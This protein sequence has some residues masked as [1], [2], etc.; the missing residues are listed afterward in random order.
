MIVPLRDEL[1]DGFIHFLPGGKIG[2]AKPLPLQDAK[3]LLYL[4]HPGA[5]DGSEMKPKA[6]VFFEP[7]FDLFSVVDAHI[8][9]DHVDEGYGGGNSAVY[10]LEKRDE[11]LLPL[12][13]KALADHL[14]RASVECG[15]KIESAIPP[16]LVLNQVGL[17]SLF[18]RLCGANPGSWLKGGLLV[19]GEHDLAGE[20]RT[21]VELDDFGNA[22]VECLIPWVLGGEPHVGSPGL[23]LM[24][25][26]DA[27]DGFVRDALNY[28]ILGER[29]C[30]LHAVPLRE[31]SSGGSRPLAGHLH[32]M[33]RNIRREK[34]GS[35][36]PWFI[37][38][39]KEPFLPEPF[40]PLV[41]GATSHSD[42]P[43]DFGDRHPIREQKDDP[44]PFGLTMTNGR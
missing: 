37:V 28:S 33:D 31:G 36:P 3:P 2:K 44:G 6:G 24:V 5:V 25:G 35:S 39:T 11:F 1:H 40:G 4:I 42:G 34:R 29:S 27:A 14:S 30:E 16:V 9:T 21:G 26:E 12:A 8:V 19:K 17:I 18:G 13:G 23:E 7:F 32:K 20:K 41:N 22:P 38:K 15:E 10:V 43:G